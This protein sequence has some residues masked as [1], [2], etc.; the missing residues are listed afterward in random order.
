MIQLSTKIVNMRWR[1]LGT[2]KR[3]INTERKLLRDDK[4][5][6]EYNQIIEGYINKG[7]VKGLEKDPETES[8]KLYLS[9]F[10]VIKP[11][12]ETIKTRIIFDASAVQDGTS[13]NNI[14][15]Q[16]SKLQRDLVNMLLRFKRD[17]LAIVGDISEMYLQI[18]RKENR[19]CLDFFSANLMR[20]SP[21]IHEFT[22][23]MF[24]MNIA[25]FEVH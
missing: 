4:I 9:H 21:V 15:Y 2:V 5:A 24:A 19:S 8:K 1:F 14:I 13:L 25:P 3:I 23:I 7:Y 12:K 10:A 18:K 20:Q 11:D 17:P 6:N 22:R 16:G